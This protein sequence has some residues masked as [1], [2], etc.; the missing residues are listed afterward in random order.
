MADIPGLEQTRDPT[1]DR[2][3]AAALTLPDRT[4]T[5]QGRAAVAAVA[6]GELAPRKGAGLLASLGRL[7]KVTEADRTDATNRGAGGA[8]Y[9]RRGHVR[10]RK[11]NAAYR[12]W[13]APNAPTRR[14]RCRWCRSMPP[15][16]LKWTRCAAVVLTLTALGQSAHAAAAGS[17]LM[18]FTKRSL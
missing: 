11:L 13:M 16:M 17:R 7:A 2:K 8:Q 9:H 3:E 12:P 1:N 6:A 18:H 14:D 15:P 10:P 5:E 4:L